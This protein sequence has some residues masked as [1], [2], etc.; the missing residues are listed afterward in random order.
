MIPGHHT[1]C[2]ILNRQRFIPL[3]CY[4]KHVPRKELYSAGTLSRAPI[5]ASPRAGIDEME[6]FIRA[7]VIGGIP[8]SPGV[9]SSTSAGPHMSPDKRVHS[10]GV[11]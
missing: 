11:A 7:T 8:A 3:S 2:L 4:S 10:K 5:T 1:E 9:L 6:E